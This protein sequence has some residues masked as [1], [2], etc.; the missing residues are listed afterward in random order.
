M[1]QIRSRLRVYHLTL[2]FLIVP[3]MMLFSNI[4]LR[5]ARNLEYITV[6]FH[7]SLFKKNL[8]YRGPHGCYI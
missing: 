3:S 2:S 4:S 8:V 5:I 6:L 1:N 7:V